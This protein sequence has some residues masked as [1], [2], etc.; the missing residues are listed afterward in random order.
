VSDLNERLDHAFRT[1]EPGPAPVEAAM[2][3]GKKI[4]NRRRAPALAGAVAVIAGAV[5][6]VPAL[7]HYQALPA[8]S[9]SHAS[10]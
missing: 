5:A 8:P 9:N 2:D 1:I 7:T 3:H 6:F 10:G 4:R